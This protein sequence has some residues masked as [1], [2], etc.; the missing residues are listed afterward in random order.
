MLKLSERMA[1]RFYGG[2]KHPMTQRQIGVGT[3]LCLLDLVS[4]NFLVLACKVLGLI[5][6]LLYR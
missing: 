1:M 4:F 3:V 2:V 5:G 6:M